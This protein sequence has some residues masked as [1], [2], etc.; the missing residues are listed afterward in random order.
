MVGSHRA[1]GGYCYC[2]CLCL[3]FVIPQHYSFEF[4]NTEAT[5]YRASMVQGMFLGSSV[6]GVPLHSSWAGVEPEMGL[7]PRR[8]KTPQGYTPLTRP[9]YP[10]LVP[11]P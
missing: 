5:I 10:D 11:T 9:A 3:V 7:R 8:R 2:Y 1:A 4:S 6:R